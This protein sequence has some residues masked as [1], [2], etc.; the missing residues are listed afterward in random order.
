LERFGPLVLDRPSPAAEGKPSR[1]RALWSQ[2][3]GVFRKTSSEEGKWKWRN[4][5][6]DEWQITYGDV[7]FTLKPT[8]FGHVGLFPEQAENWDWIAEKVQRA[9]RPLKVL[10][11]FAY[12]G[13]S[14][15]AAS[16][17]GAEVTHVDAAKNVVQWARR[18]ATRSALAERPM[19]WLAEDAAKFVQ[20]ELRR[21][22]FYDA[23]ILDPP[24]YGHGP[25]GETWKLSQDLMPLLSSCAE[26]VQHRPAF[27]LLT[28]H[29]PGF[30]AAELEAMLSDTLFG[31]CGQGV[32]AKPLSI[33]TADGRRL[34]AGIAARWPK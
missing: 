10:N 29:T 7:V 1:Q 17:A 31:A 23:V 27:F 33:A 25:K 30:G 15:L 11:L 21:E 12:T 24:S 2:A 8:D 16:S 19:R 3:D 22:N 34:N 32:S 9:S 6:P 5:P 18:N 13:G 26:L 4:S 28:C 20:R 14:T